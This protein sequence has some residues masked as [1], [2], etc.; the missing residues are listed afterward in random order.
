[1]NIEGLD[2]VVCVVCGILGYLISVGQDG[3]ITGI[4]G[5]VLGSYFTY[6]GLK[7]KVEKYYEVEQNRRPPSS[8]S[9]TG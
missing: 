4:F 9:D 8:L 3:A 5:T 2:I 1:M 6:K 7:Y